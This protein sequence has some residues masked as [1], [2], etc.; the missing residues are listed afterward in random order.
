MSR[1]APIDTHHTPVASD[2]KL[3]LL[4]YKPSLFILTKE[5]P[6]R[7]DDQRESD[8]VEDMR[9]SN[10]GSGI[11]LG[12]GKLGIGTIVIAFV[13]SYFTG[14]S[15]STLLGLLGGS[16][17]NGVTQSAPAN[18]PATDATTV[19]TRK[20]LASTEDI[21]TAEFRASNLTYEQPKL[22]IF[23]GTTDTACGQ[24]QTAMGPFY[25]PADKRVYIDL[26]FFNELQT[27]FNAGGEFAEAYVIAHE[28]GHHIQNLL[29]TS[30][31][32]DAAR[33]RVS[34]AQGNALSVRLELQA[35]CYAGVWGKKADAL[36]HQLEP[37]EAAEAIRAATA[38]GD[39]TLQRQAGR[40]VMPEAFTHGSSEQRVRWFTRGFESGDPSQCDTF[41]TQKL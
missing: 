34:E 20:I 12:R 1:V 16:G 17:S 14:I 36:K 11:S 35:D 6:V 33:R 30:A 24:G 38:I 10:G 39:D 27:R 28:V 40:S 19:F 15:P 29:G 8:N 7:L 2:R 4:V 25:C 3:L 41:K 21:W 26:G 13:V 37:N 23:E 18:A 32:V 22:R 31:K 5:K 9:G